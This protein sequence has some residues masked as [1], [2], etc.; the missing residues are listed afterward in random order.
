MKLDRA[1]FESWPGLPLSAN[2]TSGG[3]FQRRQ[4]S[5]LPTLG[6]KEKI[7]LW[8][9]NPRRQDIAKTLVSNHNEKEMAAVIA[10]IMEV[11]PE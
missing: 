2:D 9:Q 11:Q 10:A 3:A 7:I 8:D 5:T 6:W 1:D 4:T